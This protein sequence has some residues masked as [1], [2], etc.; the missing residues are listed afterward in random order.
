MNPAT[1]LLITKLSELSD[2]GLTHDEA[3][4]E[5]GASRSY[6]ISFASRH[7]IKFR[8]PEPILEPARPPH[9]VAEGNIDVRSQHMAILYKR[10]ATLEEI[11]LQY[12]VT[13]ERVRQILWKD[14]GFRG[15]DG[16]QTI[17]AAEAKVR[18]E[19]KRETRYQK[20]YGCSWAQYRAILRAGGTRFYTELKRNTSR[21]GIKLELTLWQ[22]WS[23][24][25][26]SGHY[27]E[28]GRGRRGYWLFRLRS[29]ASLSLDNYCIAT[30]SEA[31]RFM[32]QAEPSRFARHTFPQEVVA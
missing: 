29:D 23:I 25:Q 11:G 27:G 24:W 5:I 14:H 1:A 13:R 26:E 4:A 9:A 19:K 7:R 20:K 21:D 22:W 18:R 32:R 17:I 8:R 28:R 16:G 15:G 10:G 30:G 3:A 2:R 6:L 12:G 31:M